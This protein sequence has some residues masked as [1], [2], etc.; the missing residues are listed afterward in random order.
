[1]IQYLVKGADDKVLADA[2]AM[3]VTQRAGTVV[4]VG[5]SGT[6]EDEVLVVDLPFK[7]IKKMG[8]PRTKTMKMKDLVTLAR[9]NRRGGKELS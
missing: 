1:V 6:E 3:G 2:V 9:R 8:R 7:P 4:V 5:A